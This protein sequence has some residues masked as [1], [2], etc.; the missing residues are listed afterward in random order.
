[1]KDTGVGIP[2]DERARLIQGHNGTFDPVGWWNWDSNVL[3]GS[4]LLKSTAADLLIYLDANLHP[5]KYA[6]G[7]P[8]NSPAATLPAAIA[9]AHA[10]HVDAQSG[11][12]GA[13]D[14]A[15]DQSGNYWHGG[16]ST[17]HNSYAEFNPQK[18]RAIVVLY[19]RM[20]WQSTDPIRFP[21]RVA[22]N[23]RELMSGKPSIPLDILS[24]DERIALETRPFSDGSIQGSYHCHL[25]VFPLAAKIEDASK[26]AAVGDIH[27][28]AD[29]NGAFTEGS[30]LYRLV[31]PGDLTC[32]LTLVS[33]RYSVNSDGTGSETSAWKLMTAVSPRRCFQ[34]FSPA[35]P[36]LASNG[37]VAMTVPPGKSFYTTAIA[38]LGILNAACERDRER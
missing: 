8:P 25:T 18:D 14:W 31:P 33:G 16:A 7:S 2:P 21:Q 9:I 11:A 1:M 17:G 15:V 12:A 27:I 13:L 35:R 19:N 10:L 26:A 38:S 34:F 36:P 28:T 6:A 29:G 20:D 4:G 37:L 32:R 23:V 30:L 24:D 5:E 3:D 22:E